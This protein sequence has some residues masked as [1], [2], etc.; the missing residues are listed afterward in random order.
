MA[1]LFLKKIVKKERKNI[2]TPQYPCF[3][4]NTYYI[5][6]LFLF[7]TKKKKNHRSSKQRVKEKEMKNKKSLVMVLVLLAGIMSFAQDTEFHQYTKGDFGSYSTYQDWVPETNTSKG[8]TESYMI[9]VKV[10]AG[11]TVYLTNYVDDWYGGAITD[12]GAS[13]Y[14]LGYDMTAGKYG[15]VVAK[16]NPDG[17]VTP[18]LEDGFHPGDGTKTTITYTNPKPAEQIGPW[19]GEVEKQDVTGY[20]LGTFDKDTEIF[21]VM[22][23]NGFD[24]TTLES[25]ATINTYEPVHDPD[26]NPATNSILKSRHVNPEDQAANARVNL[27]IGLYDDP[28]AAHEFVIGYVAT[29]TPKPPAPFGQP[30][31]GVLLSTLISMGAI[32]AIRKRSR[33]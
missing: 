13:D 25:S 7:F 3:F 16:T 6:N 4:K 2:H 26:S 8:W 15:Y 17:T 19:S 31:P 12:L 27:G 18:D 24:P 14:E 10:K 32:T 11:S 21:L 20:K 28:G 5:R 1:V 33:K 9:T 23:P 30:L 29:N 22:T